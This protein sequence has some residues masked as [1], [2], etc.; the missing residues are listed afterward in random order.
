MNRLL[1]ALFLCMFAGTVLAR[2]VTFNP[3]VDVL[4]VDNP[5]VIEKEGVKLTMS[6]AAL[7]CDVSRQYLYNHCTRERD[8]LGA[9]GL[10]RLIDRSA[11]FS[12]LPD[13]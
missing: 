3:R 11:V 12:R 1:S 9:D 6:G 7:L 8:Y 2:T 5:Y 13:R 10:S 4:S